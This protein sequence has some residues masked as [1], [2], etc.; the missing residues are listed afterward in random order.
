MRVTTVRATFHLA[1]KENWAKGSTGGPIGENRGRNDGRKRTGGSPR[2]DG[3]SRRGAHG[4]DGGTG[5]TSGARGSGRRA[6]A[7]R[8]DALSR[9]LRRV[10]RRRRQG[11]SRPRPDPPVVGRRHRRPGVPD[12]PQR[13]AQH[14]HAVEHRARRPVVGARRVPAQRQRHSGRGHRVGEPRERRAAVRDRRAPAATA[15]TAAADDW[16]RTSLEC[17]C[18]ASS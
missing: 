10:P 14:H 6:G 4:L 18:H 7:G 12:H 2:G 8:R 15:S 13:R 9:A 17:A 1:L 16:V 3:D 11:R 5:P